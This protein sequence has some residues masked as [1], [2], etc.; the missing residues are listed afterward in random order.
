MI[1]N[2]YE[3]R[4]KELINLHANWLSVNKRIASSYEKTLEERGALG[5]EIDKF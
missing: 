2:I 3:S 4:D 1:S 5:I